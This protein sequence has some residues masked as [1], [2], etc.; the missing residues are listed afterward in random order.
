LYDIIIIF[1]F[2]Q[3]LYISFRIMLNTFMD[4]IL[5]LT[6]FMVIFFFGINN[7]NK[8]FIN[9][10]IYIYLYLLSFYLIIYIHLY[11]HSYLLINLFIYIKLFNQISN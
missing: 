9:I 4:R 10:F 6:I 11:I 1:D 5:I 3:L 2:V 7:I 8:L